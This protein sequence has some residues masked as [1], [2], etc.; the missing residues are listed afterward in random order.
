M[1]LEA[2]QKLD[3]DKLERLKKAII[4]EEKPKI[5]EEVKREVLEEVL[6]QHESPTETLRRLGILPVEKR[7][8][9]H[10]KRIAEI[11]KK[12]PFIEYSF[13]SIFGTA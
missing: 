6:E 8:E 1:I 12:K 2:K 9:D 5:K 7:V 11:Y 4:K 10:Y 13:Q 3:K